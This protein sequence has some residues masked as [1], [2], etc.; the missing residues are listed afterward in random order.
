MQQDFE[1]AVALQCQFPSNEFNFVII[2][3]SFLQGCDRNEKA[4]DSFKCG[5]TRLYLICTFKGTLCV[6]CELITFDIFLFFGGGGT[7][8]FLKFYFIL[9]ITIQQQKPC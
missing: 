2:L 1:Y 6:T 7:I 9:K 5:C 4:H 8:H 3:F